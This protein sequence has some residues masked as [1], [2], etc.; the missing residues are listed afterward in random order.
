MGDKGFWVPKVPNVP[1]FDAI[2]SSSRDGRASGERS[3][4]D[5]RLG[6]AGMAWIVRSA[7]RLAPDEVDVTL[8]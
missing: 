1:R 5:G 2:R 8:F 7:L 6:G 4:I 3:E